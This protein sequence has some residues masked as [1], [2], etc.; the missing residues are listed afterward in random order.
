[1][2]FD[3]T[4][5]HKKI[6]KAV[7][8]SKELMDDDQFNVIKTKPMEAAI[9]LRRKVEYDCADIFNNADSTTNNTGPDGLALAS[10]VHLREDGGATQSNKGTAA[11]NETNLDTALV[12]MAELL[13]GKGQKILV[14]PDTLIVPVEL[15]T[16]ARILMESQGRVGT[17]NNDTNVFR[18]RLNIFVYHHLTDANNWFILDSKLNAINGL[19]FISRL[20]QSIDRDD[21]TSNQVARWYASMRYSFGWTD[22]RSIYCGIVA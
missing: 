22:W 1:M 19:K 17:A 12:A 7:N 16:T 18:N 21:K 4:F 6:G 20:K 5:T 9:S 11:L 13:D 10:T 2:G 14:Q 15:E 8:V 3:S